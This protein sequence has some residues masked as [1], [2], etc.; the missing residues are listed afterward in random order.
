M[1]LTSND[2]YLLTTWGAIICDV[3]D[4]GRSD[5]KLFLKLQLLIKEEN[6]KKYKEARKR[7]TEKTKTKKKKST[8]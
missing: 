4:W 7:C 8:K 2:L 3:K 1:K 5:A 6:K